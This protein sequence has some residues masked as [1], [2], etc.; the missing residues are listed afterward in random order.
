VI[1][2]EDPLYDIAGVSNS[3]K[4][5]YSAFN[6]IGN[7]EMAQELW[8]LAGQLDLACTSINR[9]VDDERLSQ[10]KEV[11]DSLGFTAKALLDRYDNE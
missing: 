2:L 10:R 5:L 3:L 8:V 11:K 7:L 6:R 4:S 1:D 9:I